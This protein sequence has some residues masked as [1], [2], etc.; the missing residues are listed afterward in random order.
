M[1]VRARSTRARVPRRARARLR[2]SCGH[3]RSRPQ[4]M[5]IAF[6]V[7]ATS[8]RMGDASGHDRT[9][10]SGG[11]AK[12]TPTVQSV[13]LASAETVG[14]SPPDI[15][16]AQALPVVAADRYL[17]IDEYARGGLGRIIRARDR[18]TGRS[19]AIK[20]MLGD[21]ADVAARFVREAMVTANLQ[22]PAIV[23]VYEVGQWPDGK[24]FYAMKLVRGRA[25]SDEIAAIADLD[26]RLGLLAHVAAVADALAYAHGERIIHRDLKPHNVLCGAFGE[27]V[28]IDWGLARRLDES[29]GAAAPPDL[30]ASAEPWQTHDGAI[31]GTPSYMAPEQAR[32]ERADERTD[33]YAIGTILYHVLA[34]RPPHL[35]RDVAT[36]LEQ[37]QTAP[38]PPLPSEVPP[39]LTAIVERALARDPAGRYPSAAELASDLRR[40]MTGQLVLAHRYTRRERLARFVARHRAA[41]AVGIA[42]LAIVSVGATLAIRDILT[43]RGE[44]TAGRDEAR[45]RLVAS[46]VDRAGVELVTGHPDRAL[47]YTIASAE[48]AG[49]QPDTR[50]MTGRALEQLPAVRRFREPTPAVGFFVPGT[51][52]LVIGMDEIVR[53]DAD[54]DEVRW[55]A[56]GLHTRDLRLVGRDLLAFARTNTIALKALADGKT[57]AEITGSAG[58]A[59]TGLLGIDAHAKWLAATSPDRVDVFD[60]ASRTLAASIPFAHA[61]RAPKVAPDGERIIVTRTPNAMS[62]V[63]RAGNVVGTFQA[64]VGNVELAG[65]ELVY[66]RPVAANG[67]AQ[68]VIGDWTGKARLELTI[69]VSEIHALA[70]DVPGDRVALGT[71]D[72]LVQVR[73]LATGEVVWQVP[74]GDPVEAVSL[75]GRML[76]VINSSTGVVGFDA[77]SGI[78]VE[79]AWVPGD[80]LWSS[81]DHARLAVHARG[82]GFAVYAPASGEI[83]ALAPTPARIT[84]LA[85]ETD[86]TVITAGDDGELHRVRDG[87]SVH[88]LGAGAP[89][90]TL[91]RL[92]DGTLITAGAEGAVVVRDREGRELRRFDG[93]TVAVR[94]PDGRSL[95]TATGDA[96]AIWDPTTGTRVLERKAGGKVLSVRWSSD[97]RRFAAQGGGKASVWNADGTAVR[98]ILFGSFP[99]GNIALSG[100]GRWLVRTGELADTLYALDGGADRRLPD[101]HGSILVARFSPDD[102]TVLLAGTGSLATWDVATGTPKLRVATNTWITAAAFL[103]GGRYIIGGGIDRRV[104]VWNAE[105]GAELLAF[106]TPAAPRGFIVEPGGKRVGV[107]TTRGAMIW[108]IPAF[109]GTLEELRGL[110]RCRLD[111]EIRDAHVTARAIDVKACNR[112]V[113]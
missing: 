97:G 91:A 11:V 34:G 88:R 40:F 57:I 52:D 102:S 10:P 53:W 51:H 64:T 17:R 21:R 46:Y 41:L 9:V 100:D 83:T 33:V 31:L 63:D 75:D 43:A 106:T 71:D 76:R 103:D 108:R 81:D 84:D 70:V 67:I 73:S 4:R 89:I 96:V 85:F 37:V 12:D 49:F 1:P 80:S 55:R 72:G 47:A 82:T 74:L 65:D 50:L 110:A 112:A 14:T 27:T 24:P 56:A 62:V 19:V 25:L 8:S 13:D 101:V 79:R 35:G 95:L 78:E 30:A 90:H 54:T 7:R 5:L 2:A 60:L 23:P 16:G 66:A 87:R 29:D 69:G 3:R 45:A 28:V 93:G 68:L 44:A 39:D 20:E 26:G 105:T 107:L 6:G 77:A 98:E 38:P 22:H 58:A 15:P 94:S 113:N 18:R 32:G 61:T 109:P 59:Y 92:D 86:G 42:A 99:T 104:R 36:L 48:Q 111:L